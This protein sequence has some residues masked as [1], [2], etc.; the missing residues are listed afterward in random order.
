MCLKLKMDAVA[1]ERI[2]LS[3]LK[4]EEAFIYPSTFEFLIGA[5]S[6][7]AQRV[8][9]NFDETGVCLGTKFRYI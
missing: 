4:H 6:F 3:I 7:C 9:K 2:S 8:N 5:L 1:N